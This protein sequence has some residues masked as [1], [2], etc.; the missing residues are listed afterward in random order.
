M[1]DIYN[2]KEESIK[3]A[4]DVYNQLLQES[5]NLT[6]NQI[7]QIN[8]H[9]TDTTN[10]VNNSVNDNIGQLTSAN[11]MLNQNY[12]NELKSAEQ[13]YNNYISVPMSE[14]ARI[15]AYNAMQDR[16]LTSTESRKKAYQEYLNQSEL[17]KL[18][19]DATIAQL[20]LEKLKQVLNLN[21]NMNQYNSSLMKNK[22]NNEINLDNNYWINQQNYNNAQNDANALAENI[23]QFNETLSYQK[24]QDKIE[25]ALAEKEYKLALSNAKKSASRSYGGSGASNNQTGGTIL[26]DTSKKESASGETKYYANYTPIGLNSASTKVFN[27]LVSEMESKGYVSLNEIQNAIKNLPKDQQGIIAASFKQG[28]TS[29]SSKKATNN[30][31]K[32]NMILNSGNKLSF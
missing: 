8:N 11:N 23:R 21:T 4:N 12:Q 16:Q 9:I 25:N 28:T 20:A 27:K 26:E 14:T 10:R 31:L 15:A 7:N 2:K 13:D 22:L 19:G 30:V 29:V 5:N 24:A 3:K 32:N 6:N 18:N 1:N 17:A